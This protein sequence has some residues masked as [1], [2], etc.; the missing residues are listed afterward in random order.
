MKSCHIFA[1][2]LALFFIE[3]TALAA[4]YSD[5]WGIRG[6]IGLAPYAGIVN[7]PTNAAASAKAQAKDP[8]VSL[9]EYISAGLYLPIEVH[10]TYSFTPALEID[11][12]VR[13]DYSFILTGR[14]PYIA[15]GVI[16]LG[17]RYYINP[18]ENV[19]GYVGNQLGFGVAPFGVEGLSY[20]GLQW[21]IGEHISV[22]A[23]ESLGLLFVLPS[24]VD[25]SY[26][27]QAS[28][29]LS[30]GVQYHF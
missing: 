20:F 24:G 26:G 10:G 14:D 6:G 29:V 3:T 11:L 25:I 8:T 5:R 13:Y 21:D 16:S 15:P 28:V 4:N 2:F 18:F 22:Y 9:I 17:F 1:A 19:K 23:Q 30:T 7:N 27:I 12:G